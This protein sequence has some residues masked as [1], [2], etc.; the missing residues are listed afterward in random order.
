MTANEPLLIDLILGI[1]FAII[2]ALIFSYGIILQKKGVMEMDEI[3]LN[4]ISSMTAMLKN[5]TWRWGI[6]LSIIG[7]VPYIITQAL[8]GVALTQPLILSLQLAFLVVLAIRMLDEKLE[9]VEFIGFIILISSPVF[10]ALGG[11]A[12]PKVD[13]GSQIF[14]S[15]FI[16]FIIPCLIIIIGFFLI[17]RQFKERVI[18]VG[19]LYAILSGIFFAIGAISVQVGVEIIKVWNMSLLFF[20]I[21]AIFLMLIFNTMATIIQQLAFQKGKVGIAIGLQSTANILLAIT[22]GII[23]YHQQVLAPIFFIAGIIMIVLANG[24]LI[25]FQTRLEEIELKKKPMISPED[26]SI[27]V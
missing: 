6:I 2:S 14:T 21:I 22:G 17:I 12:P 26:G 18:V 27:T 25:K 24:L 3:K 5:K 16:L 1:I 11:V 19:L 13:I 10:L 23:I 7:G 9:R 20:A 8:I 4:D 15:S